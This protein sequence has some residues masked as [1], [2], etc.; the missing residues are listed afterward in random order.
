MFFVFQTISYNYTN[1]E[2]KERIRVRLLSLSIVFHGRIN[3]ND[4]LLHENYVHNLCLSKLEKIKNNIGLRKYN[5]TCSIV[6]IVGPLWV[7]GWGHP[8]NEWGRGGAP[9]KMSGAGPSQK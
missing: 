4:S 1:H 9:S 8:K 5:L 2:F 6:K 7:R 3:L